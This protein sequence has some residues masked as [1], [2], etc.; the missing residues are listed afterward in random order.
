MC[1]R[2]SLWGLA[3]G[4]FWGA[5][6]LI[7][8]TQLLLALPIMGI[9]WLAPKT[10]LR[11]KLRLAAGFGLG[12]LPCGLADLWY[13]GRLSGQIW[14]P[15]SPE[16]FLFSLAHVGHSAAVVLT[17]AL[18]R[19]E[20]GLLWPLLLLG[21]WRLARRA[22]RVSAVLALTVFGQLLI[23]L[24][25]GALRLRD[26]L[27]LF[28]ILLLWTAWGI[29]AVLAAVRRWAGRSQAGQLVAIAVMAALIFV[30]AARTYPVLTSPWRPPHASFGYVT[31]AQRA[32]FAQVAALTE[33][34]AVI[35]ATLSSG[36]L[37]LLSDRRS[38]HPADWTPDEWATV[39]EALQ[40][41]GRPVY[42]LDD[43]QGLA[44]VLAATDRQFGLTP[45]A[46]LN[47]PV[48]GDPTGVSRTLSR[49]NRSR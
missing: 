7:R 39:I 35:G 3:G 29:A 16:S 42:L 21:A 28:P 4:A 14:Q 30:L 8:H 27:T 18:R 24:P 17:D 31:A 25:Y 38:L 34:N 47:V 5:A 32:A 48:Y 40:A 36:A 11:L 1:I 13:H 6:Y 23:H 26:L 12:A 41:E 46:V 10:R 43:G 9:I 45:V 15:E 22:P 37:D 44:P 33:P 19:N 2:D 20:W 49:V